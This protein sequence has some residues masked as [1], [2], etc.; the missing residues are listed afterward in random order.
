MVKCFE[1]TQRS[2]LYA[3]HKIHGEEISI[4]KW[5]SGISTIKLGTQSYVINGIVDIKLGLKL[6]RY[7]INGRLSPALK[8][9]L[10]R[11]LSNKLKTDPIV[12]FASI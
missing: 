4:K 12:T 3:K 11:I 7:K 2:T 1:N 9:N 8:G 5:H 6:T 10:L